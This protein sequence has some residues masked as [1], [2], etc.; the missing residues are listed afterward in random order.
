M[1][2]TKEPFLTKSQ[3]RCLDEAHRYLSVGTELVAK[4]MDLVRMAKLPDAK[5]VAE[6]ESA[7]KGLFDIEPLLNGYRLGD[8][9]TKAE[10]RKK[11]ERER[12]LRRL[13][14]H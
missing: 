2:R 13:G 7:E 8:Y 12:K 9:M 3:H 10:H 1:P 11:Q 4:G 14:A 6:C 5:I